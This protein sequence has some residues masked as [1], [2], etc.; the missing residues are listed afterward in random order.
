MSD[1][2]PAP[3]STPLLQR[4]DGAIE[5]AVAWSLDQQHEDGWWNGKLESNCCMEAEWLLALH[6]LGAGDRPEVGAI[7]Q[8]LLDQRRG[9]GSWEVYHGAPSG[10]INTTVE[11]YFALR[12]CG[13]NPGEPE[14]RRTRDW[15][16]DHGGLGEVRVFTRYWLALFG[17]WPWRH[18]PT[19]PPEIIF[20]PPWAPLNIYRFSQW[21]RATMVP[22]CVLSARRP[23]RRLPA[24][25]RLDELF[26][27]GRDR[28]DFRIPKEKRGG[29]EAL[30][31][32]ADRVLS[33]YV[34]FPVH[35]G[36]ETAICSCL[37]WVLRHQ[38]A[39]GAWGGIQPPWIYSLLA[40][41]VEGYPLSHPVMEK[42][43]TAALTPPWAW[44]DGGGLRIQ[45]SDSIVW[46]TV[47]TMQALLDCGVDPAESTALQRAL[48]WLLGQQVLTPGDWQVSIKGVAPGG[49]AFE[50]ANAR[51][52]DV[53]DTAAVMSVL[54][55]V[56][57]RSSDTAAIDGALEK[58]ERWTRAFQCR[59]GGWAAFDRDNDHVLVTKIPFCD[60]GEVLDPPSIDVTAHVL[61][62]LALLGRD[63]NDPAVRRAIDY[64][65]SEQEEDGSWFGRWGVNH[66]YGTGSVLPALAAI[67]EDMA[68]PWI[69]RAADW[70]TS[71]QQAG[72]GW[73]EDCASYVDP[74]LRGRGTATASQTAW[75]LLA[76]LAVGARDLDRP[77]ERGLA[78]LLERQRDDGTWDE[79]QYTGTGFPGYGVGERR[80]LRRSGQTLKQSRELSRAFMI[81]YTMYRHYFPLSALGRARKLFST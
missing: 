30:F 25:R 62:A 10:D 69:R 13:R 9:D 41:H 72:G 33:S 71:V 39:D 4:L 81:N 47:L 67:G 51:Y 6:F 23:V 50:R 20:L 19:L 22:L 29:F 54:A 2:A 52:P 56:R 58:A 57:R 37:E 55:R 11:C 35:P 21:G 48:G 14:M 53:D 36:R 3:G 5:R 74:A 44:E 26:A 76:L 31:R 1:A 18:T 79:P 59:G 68:Q 40:L 61:E 78:W 80:D 12:S 34:G 60:F 7:V 45:A 28:F 46:D 66:V 49:W 38:D 75:A 15:I 27:G 70:V 24:D 65:R 63:R 64:L 16:L 17:E 77:I 8:S 73:G 32:I 42:G 43:L